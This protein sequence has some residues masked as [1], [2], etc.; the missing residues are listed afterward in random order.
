MNDDQNNLRMLLEKFGLS[1]NETE[2]MDLAAEIAEQII[3]D[4]PPEQAKGLWPKADMPPRLRGKAHE[5]VVLDDAAAWGHPSPDRIAGE[6]VTAGGITLPL[7][8]LAP[9]PFNV[10]ILAREVINLNAC[11][12]ALRED[13]LRWQKREETALAERDA[14]LTERDAARKVAI[15]LCEEW[16]DAMCETITRPSEEGRKALETARSYKG[17]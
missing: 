4:E 5:A 2:I 6:T 9:T 1:S 14:A 13:S 16:Q 10:E 11:I 7:R 15:K 12:N 3:P 17:V 8:D